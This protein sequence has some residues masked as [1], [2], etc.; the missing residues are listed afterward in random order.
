M[1]FQH[2]YVACASVHVEHTYV[3]CEPVC[4]L[5]PFMLLQVKV[6]FCFLG[7][8]SSLAVFVAGFGLRYIARSPGA[9]KV[10]HLFQQGKKALKQ[11]NQGKK[12]LVSLV[13]YVS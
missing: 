3:S 8:F 12:S 13:S 1:H 5:T 7:F 11:I 2:L 4:L 9:R 6:G 10:L